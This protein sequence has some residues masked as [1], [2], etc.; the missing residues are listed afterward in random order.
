MAK[1]NFYVELKDD[2]HQSLILEFVDF[3][4]FN[5]WEQEV[6]KYY[7]NDILFNML[8]FDDVEIP[9]NPVICWSNY[10]ALDEDL[11]LSMASN[12]TGEEGYW[13]NVKPNHHFTEMLQKATAI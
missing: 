13:Q 1:I 10:I 11:L 4:G 6:K 3:E 12:M 5:K 9:Q 7:H 8:R 2:E